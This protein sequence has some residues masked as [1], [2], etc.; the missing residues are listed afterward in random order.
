MI[1]KKQSSIVNIFVKD[2]LRDKVENLSSGNLTVLYD[3]QGR[4]SIML[5]IP[6]LRNYEV[7][8]L[9]PEKDR[10]IFNQL[11]K[12]ADPYDIYAINL[13]GRILFKDPE[14]SSSVRNSLYSYYLN[15]FNDFYPSFYV[16]SPYDNERKSLVPE[17]FVG[18]FPSTVDNPVSLPGPIY[19]QNKSDNFH[20]KYTYKNIYNKIKEKG[21]AGWR[22]MGIWEYSL[23]RNLILYNIG[24][25]NYNKKI[26]TNTGI[27]EFIRD[28]VR[29]ISTNSEK[30]YG[31]ELIISCYIRTNTLLSS[32][33]VKELIG[34]KIV[35]DNGLKGIVAEARKCRIE[36]SG[37]IDI[38]DRPLSGTDVGLYLVLKDL[39]FTSLP[40]RNTRIRLLNYKINNNDILGS[41]VSDCFIVDINKT[42]NNFSYNSELIES[43]IFYVQM[44]FDNLCMYPSLID[45]IFLKNSILPINRFEYRGYNYVIPFLVVAKGLTSK[46]DLDQNGN[47]YSTIENKLFSSG[48]ALKLFYE[49]YPVS[50][51][52]FLNNNF[53][54][55]VTNAFSNFVTYI[56]VDYDNVQVL[57]NAIR[58]YYKYFAIKVA[59]LNRKELYHTDYSFDKRLNRSS[60]FVDPGIDVKEYGLVSLFSDAA[61]S[62]IPIDRFF[63]LFS[64]G[65]LN[66]YAKDCN[67]RKCKYKKLDMIYK[68]S[69]VFG[70]FTL[71]ALETNFYIMTNGTGKIN[72]PSTS[73]YS[74]R[75]EMS[76][77]VIEARDEVYRKLLETTKYID[78]GLFNFNFIG[79]G[80][81]EDKYDDP[82]P[83]EKL[84]D[85]NY[86]ANDNDCIGGANN[87]LTFRLSYVPV[88]ET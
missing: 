70:N 61:F 30:I 9:N 22:A 39:T 31:K 73:L 47:P 25:N 51:M 44:L 52:V 80:R 67:T 19:Y 66:E 23:I 34:K 16:Y 60:L 29:Y 55:P 65:L 40:T 18:M 49:I 79:G 2:G 69:K 13:L 58:D 14:D 56:P 43:P 72:S 17:I 74:V 64:I 10:N 88:K 38:Y 5:R 3:L 11:S 46:L 21:G 71:K 24:L 86:I 33:D 27:I 57:E 82:I 54:H 6:K 76:V 4:P 59:D 36:F 50:L 12:V 45:N 1:E 84:Y 37:D 68:L 62:S 20:K 78:C 63:K 15:W 8:G 87:R 48:R 26:L 85:F 42:L 83:N 75:A 7:F 77:E 32:F 53:D 28:N 35:F 41:L 81:Y